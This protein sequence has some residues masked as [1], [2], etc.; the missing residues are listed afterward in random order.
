MLSV[1]EF[2]SILVFTLYFIFSV[3]SSPFLSKEAF[4]M[5]AWSTETDGSAQSGLGLLV[6]KGATFDWVP[7]E[8]A[9]IP[10]DDLLLESIAVLFPEKILE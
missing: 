9:P 7:V 1:V 6:I 5:A 8:S 2:V 4:K 10:A 3:V